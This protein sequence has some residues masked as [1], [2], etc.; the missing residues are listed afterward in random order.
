MKKECWYK[1]TLEKLK[2]EYIFKNSNFMNRMIDFD[3]SIFLY[4]INYKNI[5]KY[6]KNHNFMYYI[7]DIISLYGLKKFLQKNN[8]STYIKEYITN[9]QGWYLNNSIPLDKNGKIIEVVMTM[10]SDKPIKVCLNGYGF[11]CLERKNLT[12]GWSIWVK[13]WRFLSDDKDQELENLDLTQFKKKL[14]RN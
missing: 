11:S 2:E 13:R 3:K 6:F 14:K 8:Y 7:F 10:E 9:N 5:N 1:E 12:Y 4:Y